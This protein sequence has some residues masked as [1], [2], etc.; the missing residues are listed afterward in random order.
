MAFFHVAFFRVVFFQVA[1]FLDGI[2]PGGIFPLALFQGGI[3]PG[4]FF[5]GDSFPDP[6]KNTSKNAKEYYRKDQDP[7][8]FAE[9]RRISSV[10]IV[11]L[12][13]AKM[14]YIK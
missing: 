2:F 1:F 14:S 10:C 11:L 8:I 12:R 5:P 9:L 3:F 13:S 7:T 6:L 4:G